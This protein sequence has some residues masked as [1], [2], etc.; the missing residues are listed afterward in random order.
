MDPNNRSEK[1]APV[2]WRG[3]VLV[4]ADKFHE[5]RI[6]DISSA[7]FGACL[8]SALK[9]NES[10]LWAI[11]CPGPSGKEHIVMGHARVM[12]VFMSGNEYRIGALWL[13]IDPAE[14]E[15]LVKGARHQ[16]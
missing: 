14:R 5:T 10:Y 7:G 15:A 3:R 8:S 12:H 13:Q 9:V 16:T 6:V 2:R 1:R 4:A 11:A